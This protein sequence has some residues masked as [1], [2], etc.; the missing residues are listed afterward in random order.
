MLNDQLS[1]ATDSYCWHD[2]P[3]GPLL[4]AGNRQAITHVVFPEG[5]G[6]KASIDE[7]WQETAEP[8]HQLL[9]QLDSY[10]DRRLT[11]FD[12]PLAP[13]GTAFQKQVWQALIDIPY[14]TTASYGAVARAI[15]N[16]LAVRAVGNANGR[17]P[18]PIIIPCH[19]VIGRDGTLTGFGGGL[20]VKSFLIEVE[21]R[22]QLTLPW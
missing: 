18:I 5:Q 4:C 17:N 10:F 12:L 7:S 15:N 19:R 21:N 14:G 6:K 20:P 1:T 11:H 3:V 13:A 2:S 9:L 8:F 16:P 22:Q